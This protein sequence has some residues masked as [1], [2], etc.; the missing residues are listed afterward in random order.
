M[1]H[2]PSGPLWDARRKHLIAG[3]FRQGRPCYYCGH[4][5]RAADLTEV[6][7]VISWMIRPDLADSR[8]NLVPAHGGGRFRCPEPS[9]DLAC[10]Q[11]SHQAPDA[12]RDPRT[13]AS[14]PF[15]ETFMARQTALRQRFLARSGQPARAGGRAAAVVTDPGREWLI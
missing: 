3:W 8:E 15:T 12:P 14:L 5:F 6:G 2:R 10:N 11:V 7:H 1:P 13:G 4:G 9:C